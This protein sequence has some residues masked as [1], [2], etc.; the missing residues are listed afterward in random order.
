MARSTESRHR[1]KGGSPTELD[2]ERAGRADA[3][4]RWYN[5]LGPAVISAAP[6]F[7]LLLLS[8]LLLTFSFAPFGQFYLAWVGLVPWLLLLARVR[9][10]R[11][12]F[13]WSWLGGIFFFIANMWWLV[14]VTGPGMVALMVLLGLYWAAA[15]LVIRGEGLLGTQYEDRGSR[16]EDRNG[17]QPGTPPP[18][19]ILH[20]PSSSARP[21]AYNRPSRA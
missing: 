19:S 9:S 21:H 7:G 6:N 13:F 18:S 20:P 2:Y 14:Y 10:Q 12:A 3:P 1:R 8:V 17:E 15:A 11:A 4:S 5:R 16:I